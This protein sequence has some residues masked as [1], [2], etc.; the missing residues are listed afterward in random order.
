MLSL[1]RKTDV[2]CAFRAHLRVSNGRTTAL[3]TNAPDQVLHP[4][5]PSVKASAELTLRSRVIVGATIPNHSRRHHDKL[6]NGSEGVD[7]DLLC[8]SVLRTENNRL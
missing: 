1:S 3:Y 5:C 7:P 6:R 2:D 4:T 8:L